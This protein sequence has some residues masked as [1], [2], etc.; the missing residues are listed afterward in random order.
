MIALLLSAAAAAANAAPHLPNPFPSQGEA[1]SV[2]EQQLRS[3]PRQDSRGGVSAE[4][5]NAIMAQ[6]LASI[7]K[8]L[9]VN[10][11]IQAGPQQ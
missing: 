9:Q 11:S 8:P 7:G 10:T 3:P 4:E 2:I 1:R 6:Y 5:A